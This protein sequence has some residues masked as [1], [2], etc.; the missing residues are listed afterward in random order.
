[1]SANGLIKEG[2]AWIASSQVIPM[3]PSLVWKT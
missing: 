2:Q 3:F 1:M